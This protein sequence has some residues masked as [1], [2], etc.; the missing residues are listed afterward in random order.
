MKKLL[1]ATLLISTPAMATEFISPSH[2]R[3]FTCDEL[4]ED[5][6]G[7]NQVI[8]DALIGSTNELVRDRHAHRRTTNTQLRRDEL[9]ANAKAHQEAIKKAAARIECDIARKP[10]L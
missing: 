5:F 4:I 9:L 6:N 8:V 2:Y 7:Y 3:G 10:E 1:L